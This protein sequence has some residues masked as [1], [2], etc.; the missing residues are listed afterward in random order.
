MSDNNTAREPSFVDA[1]IPVVSLV[2]MLAISV[3]LYGDGS[4][5]GANQIALILASCI[6]LIIG[7][8]NGFEWREIEKAIKEGIGNTFGAILILLSVGMLIG[9]WIISGTVPAMIYYGLQIINPNVFYFTACILSAVAA[10]SIGSSW[11]VAG[12]IGI[13]LIGIAAGLGLEPEITAGAIISGAYF[14]DK[15]SPLSDTTNLAPAVAGTDL[16]THIQHMIWTTFPSIAI[17]LVLYLILGFTGEINDSAISLDA[18]LSL[19]EQNFDIGLYLLLPLVVVFYLAMKKYPAFP[20]LVIGALVGVFF[21]LIFQQDVIIKFADADDVEGIF[22]VI[23]GIWTALFDG[24]TADTGDTAM[25]E[26]LTRGGMSSMLNT[27]W[28]VMCAIVFGSILEKLGLLKKLVV[29]LIGMAKTTGSLILVTALTC[30][31]VNIMAADQYIAIVLPGRMYRLEFKKRNLA[32]KNLSRALED[33]GTVTSVLIP[34][35]TC[36]AFFSG[37]LGIATLAYA[38]YCFFN[39]IS[40]FVSVM[41]GY[42]NVKIAPINPDEVMAE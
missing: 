6:T 1:L 24:F 26:L 14:G 20:S 11:T 39:L 28:L 13:G 29:G 22:V 30:I 32:A 18:Q 10:I 7:K 4:S 12:T 15:M 37:T 40:P 9:S 17:A 38:P 21:A 42:M 25:D 8:K 35:N 31:G 33:T 27:I 5:S 19:I 41:Y 34:W 2:C 16:F 3:Y 23:K 36:G